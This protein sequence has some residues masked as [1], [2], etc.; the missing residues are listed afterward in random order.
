MLFKVKCFARQYSYL[1]L[2]LFFYLAF[3]S[4]AQVQA[5]TN[6]SPQSYAI[7]AGEL[8]TVLDAF[9]QQSGVYFYIDEKLAKGKTSAGL[10][11]SFSSNAAA[12]KQL[13]KGTQLQALAQIDGSFLIDTHKSE[14]ELDTIV[15][16]GTHSNPDV[17]GYFDQY[18]LD[19]S[20]AFIGKAEIERFK[21]KDAADM[22]KGMLNV[23]SGDARNGGG[24]DP[25]IR[26]IQGPGRV[27]VSIDDSEQAVTIWRGYRGI[28]N[29]NYIDPNLIGRVKVIKGPAID[30][31]HHTSSG[32]AVAMRTID[33]TDVVPK[34]DTFGAELILESSNNATKPRLPTLLTGQHYSILGVSNP[35]LISGT[36]DPSLMRTMYK[37]GNENPFSVDTSYRIGVGMVK[38]QYELLAAYAKRERGNYFSG[39]HNYDFY[40]SYTNAHC[41]FDSC[42]RY[43]PRQLKPDSLAWRQRLGFEVPNTS[44]LNKSWLLK[45]KYK[46]N[47][48]HI[49]SLGFRHTRSEYGEIMASRAGGLVD[50]KLA[51]WPLSKVR[52]AAYNIGYKYQPKNNPY[53]NLKTIVWHTNTKS[54]TYSSGGAPNFA[55]PDYQVA[56]PP[57]GEYESQFKYSSKLRN[58]AIADNQ[59]Q[60]IGISLSNS[61]R[62]N[63]RVQLT[64]FAR[65]HYHKLSSNDKYPEFYDWFRQKPRAGRRQESELGINASY[66]P[67][68][69][70][71]L[72]AGVKYSDYWLFDDFLNER[73]KARDRQFIYAHKNQGRYLSYQL[74]T[75][76]TA[77]ELAENR[78]WAQNKLDNLKVDFLNHIITQQEYDTKRKPYEK[79]RD[80]ISRPKLIHDNPWTHSN[81]YYSRANNPC[82]AA[83]KKYGDR[84][85]KGTCG[86]N[87]RTI[88]EQG[89]RRPSTRKQGDYIAYKRAITEVD[90]KRNHAYTYSLG[91]RYLFIHNWRV[92]ARYTQNVRFPSMFE[93]TVG[94]SANQNSYAD[95][96]PEK[97]HNYEIGTVYNFKN[98]DIRLSYFRQETTNVIERLSSG[99]GFEYLSLFNLDYQ[100]IDGI[101]L[102]TRYDNQR[103]FATFDASYN[104]SNRVCDENIFAQ[105]SESIETSLSASNCVNSGFGDG[106]LEAQA[107]PEVSGNLT[108]GMRSFGRKLETGVRTS[109]RSG[110][111]KQ[112][113][114]R[115]DTTTMDIYA[116]YNY[117]KNISFEAVATNVTDQYYIDT[118]ARSDVPAPGRTIKLKATAKF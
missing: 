89:P 94:F 81:G 45:G 75:D 23:Y 77:K 80:A 28:S 76:Y 96:Q 37:K 72:N 101:E 47:K 18:D 52:A 1:L 82:I 26:G 44:S 65:L 57:T 39:Q 14:L 110:Q 73:V 41:G 15:V 92:Y 113:V 50:G 46:P 48:A 16:T 69:K 111:F 70:L 5:Q 10:H 87:I 71:R 91:M 83:M 8:L 29:R 118:L 112:A 27:P 86:A 61:A 3:F 54:D 105:L 66:K 33:A 60:R 108:L 9:A 106:Y 6:S 107:I 20:T 53:L 21:G 93:G 19:Q 58:T 109:Y 24:I 55:N 59:E 78:T 84:Y 79:I 42:N 25:N 51:Q 40:K 97:T 35:Y 88:I 12:F 32:G 38:P 43:N 17:S 102:Q 49:I 63:E 95:L 67:N 98:A 64:G 114:S 99:G 7:A 22:F 115:S 117:N 85:I 4:H 62:L 74:I 36:N 90:K 13:L 11:G 116:L 34:G 30:P 56:N 104:L 31:N 100:M 2:N 68:S 103:L